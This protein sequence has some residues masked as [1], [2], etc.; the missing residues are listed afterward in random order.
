M[1]EQHLYDLSREREALG[2]LRRET[3][4]SSFK[5]VSA[6]PE[7]KNVLRWLLET[8]GSVLPQPYVGNDPLSGARLAGRQALGAQI[9]NTL[10]AVNPEALREIF[11]E[12]I[13]ERVLYGRN[14]STGSAQ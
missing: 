14:A 2:K 1:S 10:L 3:L 5:A 4:E 12:S 13:K 6:S 11:N 7:G 8:C 9:C